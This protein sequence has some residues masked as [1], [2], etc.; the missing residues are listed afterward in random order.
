MML[1]TEKVQL[2]HGRNY[3]I[4]SETEYETWSGLIPTRKHL[5]K[6]FDVIVYQSFNSG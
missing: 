1:S 6:Y 5:V 4:G 2:S 3:K